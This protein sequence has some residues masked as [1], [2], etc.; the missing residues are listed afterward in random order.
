[1]LIEMEKVQPMTCIGNSTTI[2]LIL[3][4]EKRFFSVLK[5]TCILAVINL[6]SRDC[7]KKDQ[8]NVLRFRASFAIIYDN[9]NI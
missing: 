4:K 7:K 1:M 2:T 3:E 8:I 6:H 5:T 9:R